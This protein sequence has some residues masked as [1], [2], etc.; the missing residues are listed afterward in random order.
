MKSFRNWL[1][2]LVVAL[3]IGFPAIGAYV[4]PDASIKATKLV[5]GIIDSILP[6]QGS[7]SGKLLTTN[8]TNSSWTSWL[9]SDGGA[10]RIESARITN[11]GSCAANRQSGAW[12]SSVQHP[13]GGQCSITIASNYFTANPQCVAIVE[14]NSNVVCRLRTDT[15]NTGAAAIVVDCVNPNTGTSTDQ[16]FHI[17]CMGPQ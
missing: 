14:V 2:P 9:K 8:G 15:V 12:I 5:S 16:N 4:I 3:L 17:I 11:N 1:L 6:S 7:N 13:T 10:W